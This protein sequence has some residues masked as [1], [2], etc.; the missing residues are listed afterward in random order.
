[1]LNG[2]AIAW[3]SKKH[4]VVTRLTA[5]EEYVVAASCACQCVWIQ[6]ILKQIRDTQHSCVEL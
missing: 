4:P 2:G 5:E 6:Q 1:M 3:A